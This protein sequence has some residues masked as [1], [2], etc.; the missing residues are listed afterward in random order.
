[1]HGKAEQRLGTDFDR[2]A[3][4]ARN[5]RSG[6]GCPAGYERGT[7]LAANNAVRRS[8]SSMQDIN[9]ARAGIDVEAA[10]AGEQRDEPLVGTLRARPRRPA[11]ESPGRFAREGWR[12]DAQC[13]AASDQ[14]KQPVHGCDAVESAPA[15][16]RPARH[17][18]RARRRAWI[19]PR[20][21]LRVGAAAR[22]S[23]SDVAWRGFD[24][25]AE[26]VEHV[27]SLQSRR[28]TGFARRTRARRPHRPPARSLLAS[29]EQ[30]RAGSR[31]RRQT[32][33][34][35]RTSRAA[36]QSGRES[37]G[38]G[39][40]PVVRVRRSAQLE[41]SAWQSSAASARCSARLA[42]GRPYSRSASLPP[43][44]RSRQVVQER[45]GDL[46]AFREV[47]RIPLHDASAR[48]H[49][50]VERTF[51]AASATPLWRYTLSTKMHVR[52]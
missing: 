20:R 49:D 4:P 47:V 8:N 21:R 10:L 15:R 25:V 2:G 43:S 1:M 31:D 22:R 17:G 45:V 38:D 18:I 13:A 44:P 16:S 48:L 46:L 40:L 41:P 30:D 24:A 28:R 9:R 50:Q 39:P 11:R 23:K 19:A 37:E 33:S 36:A 42:S 35:H 26:Q 52:R 5:N 32:A 6:G 29:D 3:R 7:A 51:H 12:A 34:F 14:S 27:A